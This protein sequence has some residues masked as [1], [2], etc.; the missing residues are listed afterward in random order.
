[1]RRFT[2]AISYLLVASFFAVALSG[3]SKSSSTSTSKEIK[4][5]SFESEDA[6]KTIKD[7]FEKNNSGYTL[8]YEQQTLD[9]NYENRVLNSMLSGDG[10]DVW[11]MPNDWVY[12]HKDKLVARPTDSKTTINIDDYV[13]PVKNSVVFDNNVYALTPSMQ[14]LMVYFNPEIFKQTQ[15]D[16]DNSE[17]IDEAT[18]DKAN[19]LLNDGTIPT[20]WTDFTSLAQLLTKKSGGKITLSGAALG[21]SNL[22]YSQDILYLLFLQNSTKMVSDSLDQAIFNLPETTPTQTTT[23]P[24]E[25]AITFYTS[26]ADSSNANYTWSDDLGNDIDAFATGKVAMIFG[27]DEI[28][29]T[30]AQKY[31][32]FSY[33]S[34]AVPQVS[35]DSTKFVD[36]AKFNALGVSNVSQNQNLAW[37][38]VDMAAVDYS[39]DITSTSRLYSASKETNYDVS[40][41]GRID[42]PEKN[43]LA[44]ATTFNKGRYPVEFDKAINSAIFA[45]NKKTQSAQSAIDLIA[46]NLT[47]NYFRKTGW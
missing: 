18:R 41:N 3:C 10:P 19:E 29:D 28:Q 11:A 34:G 6:W 5:W 1:M 32:D 40:V 12:R 17:T 46:S 21:T 30:L 25:K 44:T 37:E 23:T 4:V 42:K 2:K 27:Y 22:T 39:S 38:V 24:G 15:K 26:F 47:T 20:N 36:Y 13:T 31:P 7:D 8:T 45:V 14:A 43:S 35:T 16:Y 9:A 33:K